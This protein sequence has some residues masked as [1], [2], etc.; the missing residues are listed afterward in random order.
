VVETLDLS[1]WIDKV[2]ARKLLLWL[3]LKVDGE[4]VSTNFVNFARPKHLELADVE[5]D[6]QVEASGEN[7]FTVTLAA[8]KPAL[9]AWLEID[10]YAAGYSDNFVHLRPGLPV[11][12]SVTP[13]EAMDLETFRR[14]LVARSLT[15]TY[16]SG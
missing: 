2:G 6:V 5:I 8:S 4:T 13:K 10:E 9:W 14:R 15:D 1:R 3:D 12:V 7:Q 16:R 11:S